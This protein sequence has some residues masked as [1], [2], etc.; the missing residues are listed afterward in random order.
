M[1][2]V[3]PILWCLAVRVAYQCQPAIPLFCFCHL[4]WCCAAIWSVRPCELGATPVATDEPEPVVL[5]G[6]VGL[7]FFF[8]WSVLLAILLW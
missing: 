8:W 7:G 2:M 5:L 6:S 3:M 4:W 1:P